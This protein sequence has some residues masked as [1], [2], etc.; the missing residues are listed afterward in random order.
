MTGL[1]PRKL[2]IYEGFKL[3]KGVILSL[4]SPCTFPHVFFFSINFL[5]YSLP[6]ASSSE[7]VLD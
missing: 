3:P 1:R 7:F 2:L 5:L 4:S 6:S